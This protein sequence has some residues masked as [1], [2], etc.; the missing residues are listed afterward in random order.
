M[1]ISENRMTRDTEFATSHLRY[2]GLLLLVNIKF[3]IYYLIFTKMVGSLTMG[4]HKSQTISK[5]ISQNI[6]ILLFYFLIAP[7]DLGFQVPG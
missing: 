2:R 3:T 7:V 6:I 4:S 5:H 1:V